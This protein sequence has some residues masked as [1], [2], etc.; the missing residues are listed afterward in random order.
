[1]LIIAKSIGL[2]AATIYCCSGLAIF[3]AVVCS[4]LGKAEK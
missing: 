1:M 3:V 2:L 4:K